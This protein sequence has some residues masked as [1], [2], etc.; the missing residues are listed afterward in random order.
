MQVLIVEDNNTDAQLVR[1]LVEE[2]G[3][4]IN[5]TFVG[6]GEDTIHMMK[7][8][9]RGESRAPDLILLDI[10]LPKMNGHEVLA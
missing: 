8:A 3:F 2:T 10:N 7:S 9:S 1:A 6:N 4:P 5:I